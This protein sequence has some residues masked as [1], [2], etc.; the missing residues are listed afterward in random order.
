[1]GRPMKRT[2]LLLA[3]LTLVVPACGSAT[4]AEPP[5]ER[6]ATASAPAPDKRTPD[7]DA[8]PDGGETGASTAAQEEPRNRTRFVGSMRRIGPVLRGE[9]M[10]RNWH[11]GCPVGLEDLRALRVSYWDFHGEVREGP[12]VVHEDVAGDV[13][14][15]FERLFRHRFP[16]KH[17]GLARKYRPHLDPWHRTGSLTAAFNCRPATG[18]PGSI[19]QHSYGWAIDINPLQNPYVGSDGM[20]LR[21]AARPYRDRTLH[22][23][24]MIAPGSIVVRSFARIGWGWGGTWDSIKDYMHFSLTG[25]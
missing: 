6:A 22:E 19:S 18:N 23:P 25:R 13:V 1:M 20:T 14:W 17:I 12:I 8:G 5:E 3:T 16:I 9:M 4:S 2:A 11:P 24:G 15:V 10:G 7:E 21:K